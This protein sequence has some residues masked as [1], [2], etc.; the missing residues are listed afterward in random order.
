MAQYLQQ[1]KTIVDNITSAGSVLDH[2]D[3]I[4]YT[5]SG[6]PPSYNA[7]KMTICI[8]LQPIDPDNLYSLMISEEI[9]IQAESIRQLTLGDSSTALYSHRGHGRRGRARSS[10]QPSRTTNSS[11]LQCQ[12]CNKKGHLEHN[13]W[14]RL[15]I[16]VNPPE[17][18]PPNSS[19]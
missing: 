14:H 6:L 16:S 3:I 5:L 11:T 18:Q 8:M 2:E 4:L 9:N 13:C 17:T 1:I 7:F 12:I 10:S 19:S 15:N